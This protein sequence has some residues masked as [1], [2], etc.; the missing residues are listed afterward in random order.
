M[1]HKT[2]IYFPTGI[3]TGSAFCN[4]ENERDY[5]KKRLDQKEAEGRPWPGPR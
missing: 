4:R 2:E 1:T 3:V 5:L